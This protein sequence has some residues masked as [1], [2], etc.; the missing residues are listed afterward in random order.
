MSTVTTNQQTPDYLDFYSLDRAP[1]AGDAEDR[2]FYASN[3]LIQRLDLLTHLTQFGD[4]VIVVTGPDGS[5]K[6]TLFNRF[7][8][9]AKNGWL[10]CPILPKNALRL[11]EYIAHCLGGKPGIPL[12]QQITDWINSTED[13]PL[14]VLLIDDAQLLDNET[15]QQLSVCF[16]EPLNERIRL[17]LFGTSETTRLVKQAQE[18]QIFKGSTQLLE[19]P[20]F[21]EEETAS[22]LIY[23]LAMAGYSGDN[24]FTDTE[25]RAICKTA[26]GRPQA[27]NRLAHECLAERH[28][29]AKARDNTTTQFKNNLSTSKSWQTVAVTLLAA[30][31]LWF[32]MRPENAPAPEDQ[33]V[34]QPLQVPPAATTP[35]TISENTVTSNNQQTYEPALEALSDDKESIQAANESEQTLP[36]E[37]TPEATVVASKDT[38]TNTQFTAVQKDP[39]IATTQQSTPAVNTAESQQTPPTPD[40]SPLTTA[41]PDNEIAQNKNWLLQQPDTHYTLQLLGSRSET[42]VQ[43]FIKRH[44]LPAGQTAYYRGRYKGEDWYVLVYGVYPKRSDAAS[45][46]S[47]LPEAIQDGKPWPRPMAS[48]HKAINAATP[49][50]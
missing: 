3:A 18:M 7:H 38:A 12:K 39:G 8:D 27:T 34:E 36:T 26:E 42:A 14:L 6:T 48:I 11:E 2:F 44:K 43:R 30:A 15:L 22:Y 37:Q 9:Y 25:I 40:K 17:I 10:I 19:V 41:T 35:I 4:T 32:F 50:T 24:P 21:S 13:T 23:R 33:L 31:T 28:A 20:A 5:G 49:G 16:T 46:I 47:D 29:R 45:H 1:F